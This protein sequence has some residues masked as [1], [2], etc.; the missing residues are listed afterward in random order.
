M[1][2]HGVKEGKKAGRRRRVVGT[3]INQEP[4]KNL[5]TVQLQRKL[6]RTSVDRRLTLS[7]R[8]LRGDQVYIY[9]M[10]KFGLLYSDLRSQAQLDIVY[11][12]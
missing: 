6:R 2:L 12:S 1:V 3:R 9:Y 8:G 10:P 11:L 5:Q 4:A 7:V